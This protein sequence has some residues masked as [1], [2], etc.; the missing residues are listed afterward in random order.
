[1]KYTIIKYFFIAVL[2][3]STTGLS[4]QSGTDVDE[5]G[6]VWIRNN[7]DTGW[8]L[9]SYPGGPVTGDDDEGGSSNG[10]GGDGG[11]GTDPDQEYEEYIS[12]VEWGQGG[13]QD[14]DLIDWTNFWDEQGFIGNLF[15]PPCPTT[16]VECDAVQP[17]DQQRTTIGLGEDVKVWAEN[18]CPDAQVTFSFANTGGAEGFEVLKEQDN[19]A[20]NAGFKPGGITIQVMI[21]G[22]SGPNNCSGNYVVNFNVIEPTGVFFER[23]NDWCLNYHDYLR[24]SGGF[25]ARL[26]LQPATVNFD[27]LKIKEFETSNDCEGDYFEEINPFSQT[28]KPCSPHDGSPDWVDVS[29]MVLEGKGSLVER[30]DRASFT[31][32]CDLSGTN[33]SQLEYN[34]FNFGIQTIEFEYRYRSR[35]SSNPDGITFATITQEGVNEG[36][37]NSIFT[38]TKGNETVSN[39]L[40]DGCRCSWIPESWYCAPCP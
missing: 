28:T 32:A 18:L 29:D 31:W 12:D 27:A 40:N 21:T 15:D 3:V 26:Y 16:R 1:M 8:I 10:G 9:V 30:A 25:S 7:D 37:S 35:F 5:W 2:L 19:I 22:C 6:G 23:T 20:F 13:D 38:F 14:W 17:I 24:P 34:S 11:D 33:S 4:A 36:G 39:P